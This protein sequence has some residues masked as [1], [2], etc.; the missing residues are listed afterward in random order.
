MRLPEFF[1]LSDA[2]L[3]DLIG[4]LEFFFVHHFDVVGQKHEFNEGP[5]LLRGRHFPSL[6]QSPRNHNVVSGLT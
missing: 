5:R 6:N 2:V 3:G 4:F 1:E